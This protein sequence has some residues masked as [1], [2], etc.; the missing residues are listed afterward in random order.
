MPLLMRPDGNGFFAEPGTEQYDNLIRAGFSLSQEEYHKM[1]ASSCEDALAG[2]KARLERAALDV[3]EAEK[4]L[5][6]AN[7]AKAAQA[8]VEANEAAA[9]TPEMPLDP[10][11][12]KKLAAEAAK[13]A[14]ETPEAPAV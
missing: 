5:E 8:E 10:K 1:T 7:A 12:A 14:A 13:A 11:A 9:E 6:V 3:E 4:A 2:A